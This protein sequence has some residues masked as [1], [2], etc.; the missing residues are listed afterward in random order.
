M[1][2]LAKSLLSR[3]TGDLDK[4]VII[5]VSRLG[6]RA[7]NTAG[8]GVGEGSSSTVSMWR[9]REGEVGEERVEG[10]G[11]QVDGRTGSV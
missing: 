10:K 5:P 11:G 7:E 9:G 2:G 8:I 6:F 3:W 4:E 1:I